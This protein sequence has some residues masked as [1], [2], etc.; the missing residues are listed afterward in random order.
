MSTTFTVDW[1]PGSDVLRGRCHCGAT[2][3]A[4]DPATLLDWLGA[5]PDGH[6]TSG[7]EVLLAPLPAG[8]AGDA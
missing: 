1:L 8:V 7:P 6:D 4:Q 3:S 5:H 2:S